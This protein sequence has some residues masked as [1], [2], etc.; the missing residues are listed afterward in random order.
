M[1]IR[2]AELEDLEQ[3]L[4]L[5]Y[6]TYPVEG[7]RPSDNLIS[8]Q[9]KNGYQWIVAMEEDKL[10]GYI[11]LVPM[12]KDIFEKLLYLDFDEERD[13]IPENLLLIQESTVIDIY[14]SSVVTKNKDVEVA[15]MLFHY[16]IKYARLLSR[17]NIKVNRVGAIAYSEQGESLCNKMGFELIGEDSI[18]SNG[19]QSKVYILDLNKESNSILINKLKKINEK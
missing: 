7:I 4:N 19:F 2:F 15:V 9:I 13:L 6:D 11:G 3:M 10:V 16:L 18:L 1:E 14:I 12:K 5:D 17:N 8:R